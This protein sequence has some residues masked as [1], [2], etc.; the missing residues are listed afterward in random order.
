MILKDR[1]DKIHALLLDILGDGIE[2]AI[3]KRKISNKEANDLYLDLQR[4]L[5]LNDLVPKKRIAQTVK[6]SLKTDRFLRERARNAGTEKRPKIPGG[7]PAS[8]TKKDGVVLVLVKT[9]NKFWRKP[10]A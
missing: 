2:D 5:G 6:R 8:D 10:S 1:N 9:A 4:K 7:H 3:E